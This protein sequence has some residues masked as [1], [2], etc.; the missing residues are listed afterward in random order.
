MSLIIAEQEARQ[1]IVSLCHL[2]LYVRL[3]GVCNACIFMSSIIKICMQLGP[4]ICKTALGLAAPAVRRYS[5]K[6]TYEQYKVVRDYG[7]YEQ[8]YKR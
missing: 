2:S 7:K 6:Y 3:F 8:L 1:I 4:E 5:C